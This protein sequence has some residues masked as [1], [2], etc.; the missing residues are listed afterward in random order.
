MLQV[1]HRIRN[2]EAQITFA[3]FT[4]RSARKAGY[5]GLFEKGIGERLRFPSRGRS[6]RENVE[7]SMRHSARKTFDA[8]ERRYKH[9][10]TALEFRTHV[11]NRTL[12]ATQRL[13][14]RHL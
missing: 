14:S 5:A 12:I 11:L 10:S 3:E 6:V 4:E 9:I 13:D 2:A 1:F 8:V 7:R